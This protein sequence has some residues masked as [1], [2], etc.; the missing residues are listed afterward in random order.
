MGRGRHL[1]LSLKTKA[2]MD[3]GKL[4]S[5]RAYTKGKDSLDLDKTIG[6]HVPIPDNETDDI[7][8]RI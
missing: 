1:T 3:E 2:L 8:K 4:L 5:I 6:S 7:G